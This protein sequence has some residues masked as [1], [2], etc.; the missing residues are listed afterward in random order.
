MN[1]VV[2]NFC[3]A[4]GLAMALI[5]LLTGPAWAADRTGPVVVPENGYANGYSFGSGWECSF[6]YQADDAGC[7]A[8]DVP[9][10]A[11]LNS[12]GTGWTCMRGYHSMG[13]ERNECLKIEVPAD[14]YLI[15]SNSQRSW[16][17]NRGFTATRDGCERIQVPDNAYLTNSRSGSGWECERGYR[18]ANGSCVA[19]PLPGNAY[20]VD[21]NYGPGWECER[22]YNTLDDKICSKLDMPENGHLDSSGNDWECS[23]PYEKRGKI[24][25]KG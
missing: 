9:A 18:E 3:R 17:C 10:N 4:T 21:K 6:G 7:T 8:V 16:A 22:G 2:K 5:I 25:V 11:Y 13:L 19:I 15:D 23:K 14:G 1:A 20:L 24:C 12:R